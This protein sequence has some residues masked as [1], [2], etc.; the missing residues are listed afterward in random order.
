M[1]LILNDYYD[2]NEIFTLLNQKPKLI[3]LFNSLRVFLI[4]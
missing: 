2:P 1:Q 3:N 4:P